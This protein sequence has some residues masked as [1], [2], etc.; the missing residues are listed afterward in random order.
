MGLVTDVFWTCPGCGSREN[1][2][3]YG[4]DDD[5]P[6]FPVT[7][8]PAQRGLKWNPPCSKCGKFKLKMP[9]VLVACEAVPVDE[10]PT[11]PFGTFVGFTVSF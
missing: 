8:V 3:A 9:E 5:P 2:Q 11:R 7:A 1:A 6:E 10:E 4:G